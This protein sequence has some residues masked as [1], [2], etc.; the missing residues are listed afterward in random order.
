M[1]RAAS[2]RPLTD[3]RNGWIFPLALG[4]Y[5]QDHLMRAA[6]AFGGYANLP[7]ETVYAALT[8]DAQGRPLTGAR[9]YRLRFP[10]GTRP[11]VGAFW[12][13]SA[14]RLA[15]FSFMPNAAG[16]YSVGDHK[17][18]FRAAPDGSFSITVSREPPDASPSGGGTTDNWLPVGE[19]PYS[20]VL[21][22]YEPKGEVLDGHYAP[23]A[24]ETIE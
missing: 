16:I 10:A 9:R 23:P 18:E 1:L 13:L 19:G 21:R 5:G 2:R 11:P 4:R 17:P 8:A 12:S 22:L 15:D 20:L 24:I 6:V 14:Y 3:I 7:E